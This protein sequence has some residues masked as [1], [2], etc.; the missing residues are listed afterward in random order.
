MSLNNAMSDREADPSALEFIS[1]VEPLKNPE[2][3]TAT[4]PSGLLP[5]QKRRCAQHNLGA[6]IRIPSDVPATSPRLSL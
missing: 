2:Q 5:T 4:D 3:L 1:A 6:S